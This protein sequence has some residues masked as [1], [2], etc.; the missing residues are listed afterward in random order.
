MREEYG[1]SLIEVIGVLAITGIMTAATITMYTSIKNRQQRLVASSTLEDIVNETKLLLSYSTD[2]SPV[3]I[4]FLIKSGVLKNNS[5]PIGGSD[6]SIKPNYDN[7]SFSIN[8]VNLTY[9][10]CS[11]FITAKPKW[12]QEISINGSSSSENLCMKSG[13]NQISF[14][15][16]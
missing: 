10:D 3:S 12:S 16:Q 7:K 1:R 6:W 2:Y 8:L 14:T 9:E 4:D 11:Y 13:D 5:A 15:I